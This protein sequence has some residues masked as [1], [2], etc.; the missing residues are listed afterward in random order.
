LA[1]AR[2]WIIGIG[3]ALRSVRC[4]GIAPIVVAGVFR[5]LGHPP[6][7]RHGGEHV[8]AGVHGV[9]RQRN[10]VDPAKTEVL[11]EPVAARVV[12]EELPVVVRGLIASK[13]NQRWRQVG[14]IASGHGIDAVNIRADLVT[15]RQRVDVDGNVGA[16]RRGDGHGSRTR[17]LAVGCRTAGVGRIGDG[18]RIGA[19]GQRAGLNVEG[20]NASVQ[21]HR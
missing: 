12:R 10:R 4:D 1:V 9:L 2:V 19:L 5:F 11:E 13:A 6:E 18:Q 20:C 8:A 7:H 17:G 15:I 21:L 16:A 3:L 14:D